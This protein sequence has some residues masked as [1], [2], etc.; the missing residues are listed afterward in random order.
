MLNLVDTI[1]RL[2]TRGKTGALKGGFNNN[3][4]LNDLQPLI[5]LNLLS[6]QD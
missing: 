2:E 1:I 5:V 3:E 6:L 4:S